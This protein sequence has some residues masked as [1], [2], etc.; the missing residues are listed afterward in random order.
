MVWISCDGEEILLHAHVLVLR[1]SPLSDQHF[2]DQPPKS[3][4]SLQM[5]DGEHEAFRC[6]LNYLY[7]CG[8]TDAAEGETDQDANEVKRQRRKT[9]PWPLPISVTPL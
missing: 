5:S 3:I 8:A 4:N 2:R 9:R 7:G 6:V 1:C